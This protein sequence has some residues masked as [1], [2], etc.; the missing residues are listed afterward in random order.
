MK[1]ASVKKKIIEGTINCIEKYGIESVTIRAIAKESNVT[2]SS[3]HYYFDSKEVLL[4]IAIQ[5]AISGALADISSIWDENRNDV[6]MAVFKIL[7]FLFDGAVKF[8][9]IT[10]AGLYPLVIH[11]KVDS[12]FISELNIFLKKISEEIAQRLQMNC[13]E[14]K[15]GLVN[16]L[17]SILFLCM[18]PMSFDA[19]AGYSFLEEKNRTYYIDTILKKF[20]AN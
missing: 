3:V 16:M 18:S 5:T 11:K 17:S 13:T 7:S 1:D 20:F 19:F 4:E 15:M 6:H 9:G 2:L 14:V 10:K 12:F 8:P